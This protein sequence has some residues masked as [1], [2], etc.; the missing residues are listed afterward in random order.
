LAGGG[1]ESVKSALLVAAVLALGLMFFFYRQRLRLAVLVAGGLYAVVTAVRLFFLKEDLDRLT[2]L[3]L[4]LGSV[5]ALWLV[6]NL[7]VSLIIQRRRA[8]DGR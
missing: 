8:R 3:V 1:V 7:V 4:A 2:M 5:A 6:V